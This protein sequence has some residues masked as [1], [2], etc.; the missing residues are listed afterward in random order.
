MEKRELA[1]SFDVVREKNL[2]QLKLLNNV[3]FPIKY[4]D[5]IYR[6]CMACGELTQLAF[7]NDILVGAIATRCEKQPNGKAKAY[8]ATLGVLAPYRNFGIGDKLLTRTLA[9]C[10]QD[11]NIEE[12]SVHVQVGNDDAIC[13][14]QRHGFQVEETVKDYYK[15]LSPPDAVLLSKKLL[16]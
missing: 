1:V 6:Q 15:K 7:H 16:S 4:S 5:E 14:Y 8:I 9:A 13:F 2:E 3:I 11:P 10:A 12:A